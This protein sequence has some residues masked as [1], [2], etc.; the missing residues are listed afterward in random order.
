MR[1]LKSV[2]DSIALEVV[3]MYKVFVQ[4]TQHVYRLYI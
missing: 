2:L 4:K 3:I 1:N